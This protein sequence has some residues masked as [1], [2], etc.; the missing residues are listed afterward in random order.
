MELL[1]GLRYA[2]FLAPG[3]TIVTA[4]APVVNIE[5]YPDTAAITAA[6]NRCPASRIIEADALAKEAGNHR[7]VNMV[8][9]GAASGFLTEIPLSLFE[10]VI[11]SM[12]AS[13]SPEA[14]IK[15]F[16]LGRGRE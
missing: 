14:N 12:F 1:E 3:G 11:Q 13:R 6:I 4:S 16:R 15:A 5:N 7:A 8:M 10:D 2:D 9:A